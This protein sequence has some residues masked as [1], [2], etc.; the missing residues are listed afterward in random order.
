MQNIFL[1][2]SKQV[3]L[4]IVPFKMLIDFFSSLLS[5]FS[6]NLLEYLHNVTLWRRQK[7]SVFQKLIS[8]L[9]KMI[10]HD[11]QDIIPLDFRAKKTQTS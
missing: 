5:E 11:I 9:N 10:S 4:F 3:T 8:L 1:E 2:P 7:V 6:A